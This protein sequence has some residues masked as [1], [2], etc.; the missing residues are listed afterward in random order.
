M[1][2]MNVLT[3]DRKLKKRCLV[4]LLMIKKIKERVIVKKKKKKILFEGIQAVQC[5]ADY[6]Y[7]DCNNKTAIIVICPSFKI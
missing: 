6:F 7:E 3:I 5:M 4:I 2:E 1:Y